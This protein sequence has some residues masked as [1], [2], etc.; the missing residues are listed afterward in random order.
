MD[1]P[2][3]LSNFVKNEVEVRKKYA[4]ITMLLNFALHFIRFR[5]LK[6]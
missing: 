3:E 4:I 2:S 1:K 5:L 6:Q